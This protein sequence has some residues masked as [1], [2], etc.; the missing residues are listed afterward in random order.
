MTV[1]ERIAHF[2]RTRAGGYC[3]DCLGRTLRLG[4]G[5]NR[6]MARNAT[7]ALKVTR[8]FKKHKGQCSVCQR[9]KLVT[10]AVVGQARVGG[11]TSQGS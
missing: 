6:H 10:E 5:A 7:A 11:V 9:T 3:D 8:D 4:S 2:L 1:E